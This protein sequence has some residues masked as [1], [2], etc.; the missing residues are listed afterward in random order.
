MEW[1]TG[2]IQYWDDYQ[3]RGGE[4]YFKRRRV[5]RWYKVDALTRPSHAAGTEANRQRLGVK[6]LPDSWPSWGKFWKERGKAPR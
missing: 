5:F 1:N 6:Q 2:Y 4:W 3:R